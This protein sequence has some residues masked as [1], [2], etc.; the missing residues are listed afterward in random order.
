[1]NS[2]VMKISRSARSLPIRSSHSASP[3]AEFKSFHNLSD[4]NMA[5]LI[6]AP[7]ALGRRGKSILRRVRSR[8]SSSID[9]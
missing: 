4:I 1:M 6:V 7:A 2:S 3:S 9:I 5:R 8:I